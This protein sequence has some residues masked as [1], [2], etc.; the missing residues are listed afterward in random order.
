MMPMMLYRWDSTSRSAWHS[1]LTLMNTFREWP[2]KNRVQKVN[3]LTWSKSLCC[4][5]ITDIHPQL[6]C[7]CMAQWDSTSQSTRHSSLTPHYIMHLEN[8][9]IWIECKKLNPLTFRLQ[10]IILYGGHWH[11]PSVNDVIIMAQYCSLWLNLL[12]FCM[13]ARCIR[14]K[15]ISVKCNTWPRLKLL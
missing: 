7:Y 6:W 3:P 4:M 1:S 9:P 11:T 2:F 13:Q 15:M 5:A 14:F 8:E 10:T 12:S